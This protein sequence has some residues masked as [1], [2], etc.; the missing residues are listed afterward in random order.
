MAK[1]WAKAF[2]NSSIW[3]AKRREILNRDLYTCEMCASRASEVHHEVELTPLNIGDPSVTLNNALLHSL[4]G[5]C[6]KAITR[7]SHGVD[8]DSGAGFYF[9]EDGQLTPRGWPKN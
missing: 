2:Y 1:A 7:S 3:Q 6:H 8:N 5:D 4:C 9:N